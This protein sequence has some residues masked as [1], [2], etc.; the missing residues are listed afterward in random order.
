MNIFYFAS[1]LSMYTQ[2]VN[3]Y[4]ESVKRDIPSLFL[5]SE[6]TTITHP[7]GNID[8][9]SC[10]TNVETDFSDGYF[11]ESIGINLPFKPDVL[12]ISRERWQPEQSLIHE[13]KNKFKT[14]VYVV[15]TSAHIVNNI[16]NRLEMISRDRG[17]P[18]RHVDGYFE[19]S[20]YARQRR[21]DC[22][23][24]EWSKKSIV[25][26]NPRFD[27][28]ESEVPKE[29]I[30]QKYKI[31]ET[32][33]QILFWGVINTT[34]N[35]AF[36]LLEKLQKDRG[37]DYQIFYKPNPQETINPLFRDQFNPK[38]LVDGVEV[39]NDDEDI[40]AMSDI[41]DIHIGAITSIYNYGFYFNKQ[42]VNLNS[43][44]K[45]GTY[46]NDFKRYVDENR[47]GVEDSASFWMGVFEIKTIEEFKNFIEMD[48]LEIFDKTNKYVTD[49]ASKHISD[50]DM[51][52]EFLD[53]EDK[54][55][56]E[57]IKLFDEYNDKNAS[58]RIIDYLE[59]L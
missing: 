16:E 51:N 3:V 17:F 6:Y 43:I 59:K 36:S 57:F 35:M 7:Q 10:S 33:K 27:N 28:L 25:V 13:L 18:Q 40:I 30:K 21:T 42:I 15:E 45:I 41:C 29:E 56:K 54:N 12:M 48:R 58:K 31:D 4:T 32:K 14:K 20:E 37:E 34:R 49:L 22:L 2:L 9:F 23:Y 24:P 52:Y 39:I 55:Y 47:E 53:D 50:Y 1:N 38:F 19:H 8:K 11:I 26:G 44:C 5:Y 46:M